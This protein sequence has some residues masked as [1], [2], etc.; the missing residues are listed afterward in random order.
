MLLFTYKLLPLLFFHLIF[1]TNGEKDF[2]IDL[3]FKRIFVFQVTNIGRRERPRWTDE[4]IRQILP[5]NS[6]PNLEDFHVSCLPQ[7][8]YS[9]E[10]SH[11]F[12]QLTQSTVHYLTEN[13]KSIKCISGIESWNPKDTNWNSISSLLNK[14]ECKFAVISL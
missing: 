6:V 10:N 4:R 1:V 5:P 9:S 11:R 8:G 2:R 7:E 14:S 3:D 13:F 12:L